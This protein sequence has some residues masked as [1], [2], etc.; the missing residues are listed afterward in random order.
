MVWVPFRRV[1]IWDA[2]LFASKS[3]SRSRHPQKSAFYVDFCSKKGDF[4]FKVVLLEGVVTELVAPLIFENCAPVRDILKNSSFACS[5]I[6][7]KLRSRARIR[8]FL[9]FESSS[10]LRKSRSRAEHPRNFVGLSSSKSTKITLQ[11]GAFGKFGSFSNVDVKEFYANS[12]SNQ[13]R[14]TSFEVVF[15]AQEGGIWRRFPV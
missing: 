7:Q 5:T 13:S 3:R 12:I 10:H 6:I 4:A 8:C 15:W 14:C 1:N 11:C 9:R 2:P